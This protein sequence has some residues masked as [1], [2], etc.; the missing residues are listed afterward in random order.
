M[1]E[2]Y[3]TIASL[4]TAAPVFPLTGA[5][6]LPRVNLPLNIFEPRYLAMVDYAL[7][8]DRLIAMAQ[9]SRDAGEV[10]SPEGPVSVRETGAIGRIT[11]FQETDDGRIIVSL[12]GICRC[13][14][15]GEQDTPHPFRMFNLDFAP[16]AA[17]LEDG[18]GANMV[19]RDHL[20]SV[21]KAYLVA[22]E[23]E[24]DWDAIG[25]SSTEYLVNTLAMIS[26]YGAEE[27]QALLEAQDLK[28]RADVLVALAEMELAAGGSEPGT[29]L[30]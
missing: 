25:T 24:A 5:I 30:Q 15:G 23:L 7:A 3:P 18:A 20:L 27:K 2:I 22:N 13:V 21:L 29:T 16:F 6:L 10:E 8:G 9:P 26:P 11:A 17:D 19:D 28:T 4:P 14:I 1:M 12:T